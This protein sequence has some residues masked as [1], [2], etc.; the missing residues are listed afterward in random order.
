MFF[1][2][3]KKLKLLDS[4]PPYVGKSE[5]YHRLLVKE[6]FVYEKLFLEVHVS[7][8]GFLKF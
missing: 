4:P 5:M 8:V 2:F 1:D 3:F 7:L 6:S